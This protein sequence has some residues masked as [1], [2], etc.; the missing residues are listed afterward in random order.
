MECIIRHVDTAAGSVVIHTLVYPSGGVF[1]WILSAKDI[2]LDDFHI[3]T[4]DKYSKLPAMSSRMGD[5]E[6]RGR[7]LALRIS[8]KFG[9]QSIISWCIGDASSIGGEGV[10]AVEASIF[11]TIHSV[12][13]K[14]SGSPQLGLA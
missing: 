13:S 6:S 9:I 3:A 8:K 7:G 1:V 10:K 2:A 11:D 12:V 5:T 14:V 4:P